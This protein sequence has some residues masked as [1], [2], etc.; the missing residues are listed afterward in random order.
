MPGVRET[1]AGHLVSAWP[2]EGCGVLVGDFTAGGVQRVF[3]AV[4]MANVEPVRGRDRYQL[5]PR[6][7]MKL[8][9]RLR[10]RK[11]SYASLILGFFHSHPNG[12][13]KPSAIDLEMARGLFEFAQIYYIYAI[14][15]TT[16]DGAG[17]LTFWRLS[18]EREGFTQLEI[19]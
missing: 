2:N 16:K 8:E 10:E 19:Q 12:V 14:Q 4:G 13:S 17:E 18:Q 1:I 11:Y 3:E 9:A 5:D 15:V 6:A 7:Y